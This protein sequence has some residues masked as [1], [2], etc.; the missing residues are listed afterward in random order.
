M[1]RH[2]RRIQAA[3]ARKTG[4]LDRA[5]AAA[6]SGGAGRIAEQDYDGR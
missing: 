3:K 4:Y 5:M 6:G 1:N 2:H